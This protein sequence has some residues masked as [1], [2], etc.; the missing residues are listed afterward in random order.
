MF[1]S[2]D[3]G[4]CDTVGHTKFAMASVTF[5]NRGDA[6]SHGGGKLGHLIISP[7]RKETLKGIPEASPWS[8]NVWDIYRLGDKEGKNFANA[9]GSEVSTKC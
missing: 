8:E 9:E 7:K 4:I 2:V 5:E 6:P 3:A 1:S